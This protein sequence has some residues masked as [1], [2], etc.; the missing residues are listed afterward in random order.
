[1]VPSAA[2]ATHCLRQ[3]GFRESPCSPSLL[4]DCETNRTI[5]L[6]EETQTSSAEGRTEPMKRA[7][8]YCRVSTIDQHLET[9]LRELRQFAANRGFEV[10]GE[11]TDDG[12]ISRLKNEVDYGH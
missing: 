10:V 9:Q 6:V 12:E 2:E 4:I 5:R 8:L 7:A 1:M 3:P 11:Y